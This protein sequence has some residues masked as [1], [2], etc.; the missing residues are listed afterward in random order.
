MIKNVVTSITDDLNGYFQHRFTVSEPK[1]IVS[2]L[3]GQDGSVPIGTDNRII[4]SVINIEQEHNLS[5][6]KHLSRNTIVNTPPI[7]LNLY[8]MFSSNF[9]DSNYLEGLHF[10]SSVT[11]FFQSKP[12]FTPQNTPR[13]PPNTEKIT[14]EIHN[15]HVD[16]LGNLWGAIGAKYMPSIIYKLRMIEIAGAQRLEEIQPVH[17]IKL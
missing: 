13:L 7:Y 3:I 10:L 16:N 4:C 5:G 9:T 8:L 1:V 11:S 14:A 12:V 15:V 17:G 2:N 6:G